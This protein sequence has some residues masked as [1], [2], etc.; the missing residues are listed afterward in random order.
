MTAL[1]PLVVLLLVVGVCGW[2]A[3][4]AFPKMWATGRKFGLPPTRPERKFR[5]FV[6]SVGFLAAVVWWVYLLALVA[7]A[8]LG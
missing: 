7:A 2:I 3:D 6:K 8:V 5:L 4:E 1:L